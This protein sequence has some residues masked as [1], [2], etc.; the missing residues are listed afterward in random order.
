MVRSAWTAGLLALAVAPGAVAPVSA[1]AAGELARMVVIRPKPGLEAEFEAGYRRHLEWHRSA[2]D[3]WTWYGWRFVLGERLDL[4]MDGSFGHSAEELDRAIR[5]A[6]D[7]ADN[8]TNVVPYA[9]FLAHGVWERLPEASRGAPLPDPSPFLALDTFD[10]VPGEEA[11]FEAALTGAALA[12]RDERFSW[13]RLR[14]GGERPRY[15]LMRAASSFGAG[16]ALEPVRFAAGLIERATSEL[17]R[18]QPSMSYV[19]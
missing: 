2:G 16:A 13:F 5:P 8:A 12:A 15:A 17:L 1:A 10:V 18:Y 6:D 7:G 3:P 4:F 9:D 14:R 11:A 19:P